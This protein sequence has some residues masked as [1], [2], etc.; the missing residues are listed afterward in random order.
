M[1]E[2]EFWLIAG[3]HLRWTVLVNSWFS[4]H[5]N[6]FVY[7]RRRVRYEDVVENPLPSMKELYDFMNIPFMEEV[8]DRIEAHFGR[9]ESGNQ[10]LYNKYFS[11]YRNLSEFNPRHWRSQL[12][13]ERISRI[14]EKCRPVLEVLGYP[15]G[16]VPDSWSRITR[17]EC[18]CL[19]SFSPLRPDRKEHS[20]YDRK[21]EVEPLSPFRLLKFD[22]DVAWPN[23]GNINIFKRALYLYDVQI[24]DSSAFQM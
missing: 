19:S 20:S 23:G 8:Q 21:V 4:L 18:E 5:K 22:I 9:R 13:Q 12:E 2:G 16:D 17:D 7:R 6:L 3:A 24:D 10:I 11:T 14:E 15:V 1:K